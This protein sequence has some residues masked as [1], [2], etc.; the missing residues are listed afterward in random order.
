IVISSRLHGCICALGQ[1]VPCIATGWNHKY[2]ELYRDF[3]VPELML[4][5]DAD[6]AAIEALVERAS[7]PRERASISA[8]LSSRAEIIKGKNREMWALVINH[9]AA[10]VQP[11]YE[12][13]A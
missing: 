5:E 9:L 4:G 2:Q 1:G 3:D 7:D 13:A 12:H 11:R 6:A 10:A 8:R